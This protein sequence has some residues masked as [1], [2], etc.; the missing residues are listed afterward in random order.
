MFKLSTS[1]ERRLMDA[2]LDA[3]MYLFVCSLLVCNCISIFSHFRTEYV[4]PERSLSVCVCV[5]VCVRAYVI[6]SVQGFNFHN[7]EPFVMKLE[8]YNLNNFALM[9]FFF[10][11]FLCIRL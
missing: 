1:T 9:T 2:C 7:F 6:V 5:C 8:P 4:F 10:N 11:S 3:K